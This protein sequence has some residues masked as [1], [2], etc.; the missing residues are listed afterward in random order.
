MKK[1]NQT[2]VRVGFII[3]LG[4]ISFIHYK[5][6]FSHL[7]QA[8][9]LTP[10]PIAYELLTKIAIKRGCAE[11]YLDAFEILDADFSN[12][13]Q[14]APTESKSKKVS[15]TTNATKIAISPAKYII[16]QDMIEISN[17]TYLEEDLSFEDSDANKFAKKYLPKIL[18]NGKKKLK[19][20]CT[21]YQLNQWMTKTLYDNMKGSDRKQEE[22]P[23][24]IM[25]TVNACI[26]GET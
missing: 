4:Y 6:I 7:K 21:I 16:S 23:E 8:L 9:K 24:N 2:K 1:K 12:A 18:Y 20:I 13:D 22:D 17:K 15:K 5:S 25:D 19:W 3:F 26:S 10:T 11:E 14:K